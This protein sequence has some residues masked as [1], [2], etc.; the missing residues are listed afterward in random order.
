MLITKNQK[1]L[2]LI[3]MENHM[4]IH[5]NYNYIL[6]T[7]KSYC[8]FGVTFKYS[9]HIG[10]SSNLLMEKGRKASFKIKKSIGLNNPCGFNT[11]EI[12]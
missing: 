1:S 2:Y 7:V 11:R 10:G 3:I 4:K 6:E 8:Y 12:V 5:S 9:G